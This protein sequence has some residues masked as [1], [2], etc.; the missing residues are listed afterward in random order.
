MLGEM[1]K[2]NLL[3]IMTSCVLLTGAIFPGRLFAEIAVEEW[4]ARYNRGTASSIALDNSGNVYITGSSS[5]GGISKDYA[6]IKYDTDGNQ[7]WVAKYNGPGNYL[8]TAIAIAVDDSGN[9]YV[10]GYTRNDSES[11]TDYDYATIKY[12]TDGNQQWVAIYTGPGTSFDS[13]RA[14]AVD[15]SGNVYVTGE[16]DGDGTGSDYATIKYDTHTGEQLWVTRHNGPGNGDDWVEA[17]VL[18]N[19]GNVYVTGESSTDY[20]TIKYDTHTGE[21]LWVAR[22][23]GLG[24]LHDTA[25]AIALDNSGNVYVTGSTFGI[26]VGG[27][28]VDYATIKYDTHTGKQL[29][30][31]TY[32]SPGNLADYP[33]AMVVDTLGNVYVLGRSRLS[34]NHDTAAVKYAPDGTQLWVARHDDLRYFVL[35]PRAIA[36]DNSGNVYIT[37][38]SGASGDHYTGDYTTIKHD[39]HTGE[40]L[41]VATY[42]GT[43]NSADYANAIAVDDSGNVYVTGSSKGSSFLAWEYATVK[44]SQLP[45]DPPVAVCQD[46]TVMAGSYC[47]GVVAP[48]DVDNGSSDPDGDAITLSLS[49]Q[50]PYA[51]GTTSVTLTVTD[52]HGVSSTCTATVKVLTASEGVLQLIAKVV[53]LNLHNGIENSL[54][55]KLENAL[56]ALDDLNTN[57]D[58]S[59]INAI[60]AFINHVQA[61]SGDKISVADADDLIYAAINITVALQ[62]G[63]Y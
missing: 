11:F 19:S 54:D 32:N 14:I 9:V 59:A 13:P 3:L 50:G 21:Q 49:P 12:D 44:Y 7:Q 63:C 38:S 36:L 6:T 18:D 22:Y 30:V 48:E 23:N 16:S 55:A 45:T 41:W 10:T 42:N 24:N 46:I 35:D 61:Q 17:M 62:N 2:L 53:V 58:V 5:D 20:G 25:Y 26:G 15:S 47:E 43:G 28:R 40:Q 52:E 51:M 27:A 57:N 8:D 60:E 29:W 39:T 37:G 56:K 31:K 1:K 4:V 34:G 33:E